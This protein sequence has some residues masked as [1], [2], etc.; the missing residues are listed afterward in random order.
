MEDAKIDARKQLQLMKRAT[1]PFSAKL[2]VAGLRSREHLS[3]CIEEGMDAIT[4]KR[5]IFEQ[6]VQNH[7]LTIDA[8]QQFTEDAQGNQN[9]S[10]L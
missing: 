5:S 3:L 4:L 1:Q 2:L 8:V 9:W 10:S 7:P 6:L